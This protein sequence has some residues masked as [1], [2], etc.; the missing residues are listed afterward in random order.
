L[1]NID[2]F[3]SDSSVDK[4]ASGKSTTHTSTET[5]QTDVPFE[6][7]P[8]AERMRPDSFAELHGQDHIFGEGKPLRRMIEEDR[9]GSLI[10][11]GPPGSGK[12]TLAGIAAKTSGR[13]FKTLSAV[14]SGIKEL[15]ESVKEARYNQSGGKKTVLFIDEIH[16]YNKTQQDALLP[17]VESGLLT[18]IGATTEN[19]SFGVI[20]ALRSRCTVVELKPLAD[21]QVEAIIKNAVED[22]KK[23]FGGKKLSVSDDVIGRI[24]LAS[25]GDARVALQILEG[26]EKSAVDGV[27]DAELVE[28]I[29]QKAFLLYDKAGQAHYD[30]ASAFQKSLRGS[31]PDAAI[32]WLARMLT[33]G[34]DPRYIAR[35]L[36]VTASEDVGNADPT[37]LILAMSALDAVEKI[38]LPEGRIP[39]AQAT[40]YVALA[41]KSNSAYKAI[42]SAMERV[43]EDGSSPQIPFHLRDAAYKRASSDKG[44]S[45][46]YDY[47]HGH[48]DH[49]VDQQYLPDNLIGEAF[50]TPSTEGRE[51]KLAER[52]REIKKR[53]G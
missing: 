18:L 3:G 14:E 19:P 40:I 21:D 47:P 25:G 17:H 20:P 41:P 13:V 49:W 45:A 30:H 2:L 4:P 11:W 38:G 1:K 28:E 16:R 22:S 6:S 48:P 36:I 5:K 31:D 51:A 52:L 46:G 35:R 26:C 37:A 27:I 53:R 34:E 43:A 12:T 44:K 33:A 42:N 9:Y 7:V 24:G 32:Y 10:V 15:K 8:L 39:L 23:G 50:Y 29:S